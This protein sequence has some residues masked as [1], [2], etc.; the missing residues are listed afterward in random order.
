MQYLPSTS[1][2]VGDG[3]FLAGNEEGLSEPVHDAALDAIRLQT[4]ECDRLESIIVGAEAFGFWGGFSNAIL[5]VVHD[6]VCPST[7]EYFGIMNKSSP[8]DAAVNLVLIA[9]NS[10]EFFPLLL[11]A[12]FDSLTSCRVAA[13]LETYLTPNL[14][15]AARPRHALRGV[16]SLLF[17]TSETGIVPLESLRNMALTGD[18]SRPSIDACIGRADGINR[19]I[20]PEYFDLSVYM[21]DPTAATLRTSSSF[22]AFDNMQQSPLRQHVRD[23]IIEPIEGN[24]HLSKGLA[25]MG[26]SDLRE[27]LYTISSDE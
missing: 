5:T 1:R 19:S 23:R 14:F 12:E 22:L 8:V 26:W 11:D 16:T 27:C 7:I 3:F 10:T 21:S 24:Y 18:H 4:E 20:Y 2:G 9:E 13:L 6:E 15:P 17:G 25:V